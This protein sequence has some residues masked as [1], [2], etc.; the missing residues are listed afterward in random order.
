MT[1]NSSSSSSSSSSPQG[2]GSKENSASPLSGPP[3]PSSYSYHVSSSIYP[4][5]AS[6]AS[7]SSSAAGSQL[8]FRENRMQE[9]LLRADWDPTTQQLE[10]RYIIW[11]GAEH[12][13]TQILVNSM[14]TGEELR[15]C[16]AQ[17]VPGLLHSSSTPGSSTVQQIPIIDTLSKRGLRQ[18]LYNLLPVDEQQDEES[19]EDESDEDESDEADKDIRARSGIAA[20]FTVGGIEYLCKV[21][22]SGG[23][24]RSRRATPITWTAQALSNDT[25]PQLGGIHTFNINEVP[26]QIATLGEIRLGRRRN[27]DDEP[28]DAFMDA[29]MGRNAEQLHEDDAQQLNASGEPSHD[30][31][32][33]HSIHSMP[34][35][36]SFPTNTDHQPQPLSL[37]TANGLQGTST[38]REFF[39]SNNTSAS[40]VEKLSSFF[41]GREVR[42]VKEIAM[43]DNLAEFMAEGL[44]R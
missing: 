39:S 10:Q 1:S 5:S 26:F 16:L 32:V 34:N 21:I 2:D 37:P 15:D 36:G 41:V 11:G 25:D 24:G 4:I 9:M 13:L 22:K 44:Y 43:I 17:L 7:S 35:W 19:N 23:R 8:P 14:S 42:T 3:S 30:D 18:E 27:Q 28:E 20:F 12:N 31:L 40:L 6:P 29:F 33:I 38:V